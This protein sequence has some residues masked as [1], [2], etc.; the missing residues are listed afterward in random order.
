MSEGQKFEIPP[1]SHEPQSVE[2]LLEKGE[3]EDARELQGYWGIQLI[4]IKDDGEALFRPDKETDFLF[5]AKGMEARRSDLELLAYKIDQILKFNLVPAV[6]SR[7]VGFFDG[8]LQK[9]IQNFNSA[10]SMD[11]ENKVR[12][13]EITR[14]AIFDYLLDVRDR[15]PGN[16]IIDSDTGKLWLIDHDF[17]MFFG[18]IKT[19]RIVERATE[20]NLT[21]LGETEKSS[22]EGFLVN[23]DSF[24]ADAKPEIGEIIRKAVDR[25]KILL[26]QGQI[27]TTNT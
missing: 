1:K 15:H 23:A 14:A 20:K 13:E 24:Y 12:P 5:E 21:S 7:T 26:E 27:P 3:I 2:A 19:S 4:K 25:T 18:S 6:T 16:F 11:W 9:R 10:S 17:L 8:S 22:L